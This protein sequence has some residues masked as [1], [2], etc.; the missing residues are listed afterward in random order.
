MTM[1]IDW[2]CRSRHT[3]D[4]G[5]KR[6][7]LAPA[8]GP[9]PGQSC[10]PFRQLPHDTDAC[11]TVGLMLPRLALPP[12]QA[13]TLLLHLD[14]H[15]HAL[16]SVQVVGL[17]KV[18]VEGLQ[19]PLLLRPGGVNDQQQPVQLL[20]TC[21]S[22][23]LSDSVCQQDGCGLLREVRGT[24]GQPAQLAVAIGPFGY[25]GARGLH[26]PRTRGVECWRRCH[27]HDGPHHA[28]HA[29]SSHS[30]LCCR[31][32]TRLVSSRCPGCASLRTLA[33]TGQ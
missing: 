1:P 2:S 5:W 10:Q 15:D 17:R 24:C 19:L 16:P 33:S 28:G 18:T 31:L 6:V 7:P 25:C 11:A 3:R 14:G 13:A 12:A 22:A 21:H 8:N 23:R 29:D 4:R 27:W 26:E 30:R 20:R 9:L 32:R